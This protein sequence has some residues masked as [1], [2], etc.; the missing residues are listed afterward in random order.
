MGQPLFIVQSYIWRTPSQN[1]NRDSE[2]TSTRIKRLSLSLFS[3]LRLRYTFTCKASPFA[4]LWGPGRKRGPSR[5][6]RPWFKA[7]QSSGQLNNCP[8][9]LRQ[10]FVQKNSNQARN[11]RSW[12]TCWEC[13][14]IWQSFRTLMSRCKG[15][16][17]RQPAHSHVYK[18]E[19]RWNMTS[20]YNE[21]RQ[22]PPQ[23]KIM[24]LWFIGKQ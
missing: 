8:M 11:L 21:S 6:N 13:I 12:E 10:H 7:A 1:P 4:I 15:S 14:E 20:G 23:D 19:S 18:T 24:T 22:L 2:I 5:G 17:C 3:H 16:V 9:S